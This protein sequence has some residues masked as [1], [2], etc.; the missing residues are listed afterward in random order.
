MTV[1]SRPR[2][3]AQGMGTLGSS[4]RSHA[5]SPVTVAALRSTGRCDLGAR[6]HASILQMGKLKPRQIKQLPE[7][8][9][10]MGGRAGIQCGQLD[11]TLR[12]FSR[13]SL[14]SICPGSDAG[15]R[16]DRQDCLGLEGTSGQRRCV[17]GKGREEGQAGVGLVPRAA[18]R[19]WVSRSGRQERKLPPG[20]LR[21]GGKGFQ[22][23]EHH[24]PEVSL[25][26]SPL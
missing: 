7:V 4:A 20:R 17:L 23:P 15:R 19:P 13:R 18:R 1:V 6:E 26:S 14:W 12:A 2:P 25:P 9:Q 16:A 8:T 3:T 24:S 22:G 10:L 11:S 21:G 5:A